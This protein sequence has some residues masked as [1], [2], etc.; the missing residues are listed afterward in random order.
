MQTR[1]WRTGRTA[2]LK[3]RAEGLTEQSMRQRLGGD[4]PAARSAPAPTPAAPPAEPPPFAT[5]PVQTEE[6]S[7]YM[8]PGGPAGMLGRNPSGIL[9]PITDFL[10]EQDLTPPVDAE[11]APTTG[12]V[13]TNG[14]AARVVPPSAN[15]AATSAAHT[16]GA[17]RAVLVAEG[18]PLDGE[19][20][21]LVVVTDALEGLPASIAS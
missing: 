4:A 20:A 2:E 16:G 14:V 13:V 9:R 5:R 11:T 8:R 10:R 1:R 19:I 21:A 18:M 15:G 6:P 17:L 7:I 3:Q 12:A